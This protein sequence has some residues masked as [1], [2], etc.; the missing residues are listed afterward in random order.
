MSP[1]SRFQATIVVVVSVFLL[2]LYGLRHY[3][4]YRQSEKSAQPLSMGAIVQISGKVCTPG[5]YSFD[6]PVTVD[7]AVARAGGLIAGLRLE[8]NWRTVRVTQGR[9]VHI[10]EGDNGVARLR[11]EWMAVPSLLALGER[12]ELN[13]ASA[14]EL[15][16]VPGI[17]RELAERIVAHR[18]RRGGFSR[19]DDLVA[20]K[21][22]GPATIR[23]LRPHLKIN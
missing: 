15:A 13:H 2:A 5:I 9:R 1:F 12:L 10:T 4:D 17:S 3:S 11:L 18:K 14:N 21:G 22:I 7:R 16:M 6:G 19:L 8:S 23:R 20:V